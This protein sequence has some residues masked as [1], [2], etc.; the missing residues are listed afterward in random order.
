MLP[1]VKNCFL[2]GVSSGAVIPPCNLPEENIEKNYKNCDKSKKKKKTRLRRII[3]KCATRRRTTKSIYTLN[4]RRRKKKIHAK[5]SGRCDVKCCARCSLRKKG[6][7]PK[8]LL[9]SRIIIL[10]QLW[11]LL[12]N[13]QNRSDDEDVEYWYTATLSPPQNTLWLLSCQLNDDLS[14]TVTC[15]DRAGRT[16]VVR[17]KRNVNKELRGVVVPFF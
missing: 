13:L 2:P 9:R 1:V 8:S 12:P 16:A 11:Y 3:F 5:G 10:I 6:C 7:P 4:A 17:A 15:V 14:V